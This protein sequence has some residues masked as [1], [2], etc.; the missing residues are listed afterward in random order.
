MDWRDIFMLLCILVLCF[1]GLLGHAEA[2][3]TTVPPIIVQAP[4][5]ETNWKDILTM[6]IPVLWGAIGPVVIA[7]ITKFVN[8]GLGVY[9]PRPL[10]V[11][12]SSIMGAV[13]A[14]L[15]GDVSGSAG[16][17]SIAASAAAGGT[18][19]VYAQTR[20]ETLRASQPP[21]ALGGPLL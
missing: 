5:Q 8:R 18:S 7:A 11:I 19:Q 6:L 16:P 3:T 12:L 1:F 14:G 17:A 21:P 9:V 4:V 13:V 10:Q 2:Q 20:P 15:T